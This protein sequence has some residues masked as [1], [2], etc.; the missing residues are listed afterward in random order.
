MSFNI[1]HADIVLLG[2]VF[3]SKPGEFGLY[4]ATVSYSYAYKHDRQ[5]ARYSWT[6]TDVIF[7]FNPTEP[8][9]EN[10]VFFLIRQQNMDLALYCMTSLEILQSDNADR[11]GRVGDVVSHIRKIGTSK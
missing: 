6:K 5:L 4:I 2:H 1:A 3:S 8:E 9:Y 7:P 10:A 11:F